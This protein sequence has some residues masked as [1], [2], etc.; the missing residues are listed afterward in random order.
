MLSRGRDCRSARRTD[1]RVAHSILTRTQACLLLRVAS[2]VQRRLRMPRLTGWP[3]WRAASGQLRSLAHRRRGAH[4]GRVRRGAGRCE[5][6]HRPHQPTA[7]RPGRR[8]GPRAAGV[9][10]PEGFAQSRICPSALRVA[11]P[12]DRPA[13]DPGAQDLSH[14]RRGRASRRA[15][16]P[17]RAQ[18]R[19]ALDP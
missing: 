16:R 13:V 6:A 7:Q 10:R 9:A 2:V 14:A 18:S 5:A 4:A 12:D 11:R 8:A 17:R 19:T 1:T 15:R 3:A